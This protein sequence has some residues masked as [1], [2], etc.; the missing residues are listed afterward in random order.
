MISEQKPI[1]LYREEF[2]PLGLKN[3]EQRRK[4]IKIRKNRGNKNAKND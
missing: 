1:K 2:N 3:R 4:Y